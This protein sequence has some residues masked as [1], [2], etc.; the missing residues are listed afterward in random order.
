M[1]ATPEVY[2]PIKRY[3]AYITAQKSSSKTEGCIPRAW[4][5]CFKFQAVHAIEIGK[6]SMW[7]NITESLRKEIKF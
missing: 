6:G 5:I 3:V 1:F 4:N 7:A 2:Y